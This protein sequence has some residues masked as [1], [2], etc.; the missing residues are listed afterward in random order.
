MKGDPGGKEITAGQSGGWVSG[1]A[2]WKGGE[3]VRNWEPLGQRGVGLMG[4]QEGREGAGHKD[5]AGA[6]ASSVAG[7]RMHTP[8][9]QGS[10]VPGQMRGRARRLLS[11]G[12]ATLRPT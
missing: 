3:A 1:G 4:P 10:V 5:W 6:W 11:H 7:E 8:S 12:S 9:F 2:G